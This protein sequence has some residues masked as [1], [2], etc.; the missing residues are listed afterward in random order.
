MNSSNIT[1]YQR[2]CAAARKNFKDGHKLLVFE[3][4][5]LQERLTLNKN[6]DT[7]FFILGYLEEFD[8]L[9]SK[10]PK[11]LAPEPFKPPVPEA[12]RK[13]QLKEIEDM[14]QRISE[15]DLDLDL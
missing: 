10:L 11:I 3:K 7:Q 15:G 13:Q 1:P 14:K 2:G 12:I 8:Y 9:S 4:L 6:K 5:S